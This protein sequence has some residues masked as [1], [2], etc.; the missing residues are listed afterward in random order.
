M[1]ILKNCTNDF[2]QEI[3]VKKNSDHVKYRYKIIS[4]LIFIE[5]LWEFFYSNTPI[6]DEL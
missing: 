4:R 2:S 5:I 1:Q 6:K 3:E